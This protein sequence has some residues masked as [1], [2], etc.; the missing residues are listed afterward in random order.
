MDSTL[1]ARTNPRTNPR[2]EAVRAVRSWRAGHSLPARVFT[3]AVPVAAFLAWC[4]LSLNTAQARVQ[5]HFDP[6]RP[7]VATTPASPGAP[8]ASGAATAE[9]PSATPALPT[10]KIT[11]QVGTDGSLSA[12]VDDTWVK[13]GDVVAG[14]R[15]TALRTE[16]IDLVSLADATQRLTLRLNPV[17]VN[18]N[19]TS[20]APAAW[21]ALALEKK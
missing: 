9:A 2:L 7:A 4:F 18:R 19:D 8:A 16:S 12:L 10:L 5:I 13:R 1:N 11:R 17:T 3:L 15:V 20:K 21:P 14:Y 6:M